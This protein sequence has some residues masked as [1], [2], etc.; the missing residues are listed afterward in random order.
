MDPM[1]AQQLAA[2]LEVEM[3]AD[4]YNRMTNACHRK[5]V[6]PIYNEPELTK[7]ESVCLDRCVAK[8]LDLHER[9]GRKLTELS[10]QDEEMMRKASVGSG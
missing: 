4:M 3:M 9:L 8:Y 7:G 6:P 1:K 10:I 5:C 2:E